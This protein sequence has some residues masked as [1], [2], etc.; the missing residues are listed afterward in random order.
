MTPWLGMTWK[1]TWDLPIWILKASYSSSKRP[2]IWNYPWGNLHG[3]P[4]PEAVKHLNNETERPL[5]WRHAGL[6]FPTPDIPRIMNANSCTASSFHQRDFQSSAGQT[7]VPL[8]HFCKLLC[9]FSEELFWPSCNTLHCDD[10]Y[11]ILDLSDVQ[12]WFPT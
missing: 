7:N 4:F 5:A 3:L 12:F 8:P 6:F 2:D 11:F 10:R 1:H 9:W